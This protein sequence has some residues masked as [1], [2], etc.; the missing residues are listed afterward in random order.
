MPDNPHPSSYDQVPYPRASYRETHPDSLAAIATLF[1]MD[2]APVERCR[3]LELACAAGGNLIPMASALPNSEFVGLDLSARQIALGQAVIATLGLRNIRLEQADILD[4]GAEQGPFDYLIAHGLYSWVP[5]PVRD[6]MLALCG[7]L[8]RPNGVAVVSYNA[9]PGGHARRMLRDMMLFHARHESEPQQ[10][11]AA[12]RALLPALLEAPPADLPDY[13]AFLREGQ[14]LLANVPDA[15]V[16]H[17]FLAEVNEPIPLHEFVE[18][19]AGH[20]LQYLADAQTVFPQLP[21]ALRRRWA[22]STGSP[23]SNTPTSST[24]VPSA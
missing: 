9:Q 15:L 18:R 13:A 6:Q 10:R 21:P 22:R 16:Y 19:A 7:L 20:G 17:E 12:A 14:D 1:G 2:P 3:V 24:A 11:V 5:P 4:V 23:R 8:L